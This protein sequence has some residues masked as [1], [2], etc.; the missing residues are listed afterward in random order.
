MAKQSVEEKVL[1][2]ATPLCERLQAEIVDVE[3]QKEGA[4][5]YL[6]IFIDCPQGVDHNLCAD[7]SNALGDV[8]DLADWLPEHYILEVSSPGVERPLKKPLDFQR[9]AGREIVVKLYQP[10]EGKKEF[11]GTLLGFSESNVLLREK[12]GKEYAFP[13]AE[14][15]KAHLYFA[16]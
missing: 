13:L 10:L 9:F 11:I 12:D 1:A 8:L 5:W 2:M 6:R 16:F 4:Q 14:I 15:A 7:V 3:W